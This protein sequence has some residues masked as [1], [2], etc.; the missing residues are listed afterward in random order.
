LKT[1]EQVMRDGP[2]LARGHD[3]YEVGQLAV[4]PD[5]RLLPYAE[6]T[7]GRRQSHGSIC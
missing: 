7:V 4:S 3:Y 2:Q 5:N 6:D 1:L